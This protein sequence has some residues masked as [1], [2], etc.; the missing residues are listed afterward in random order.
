VLLFALEQL[1]QKNPE[2][3]VQQTSKYVSE[4]V[5]QAYV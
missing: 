4:N 2:S 5:K 1:R 3:I